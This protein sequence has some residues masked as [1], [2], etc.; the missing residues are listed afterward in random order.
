M[1]YSVKCWKWMMKDEC[2]TGFVMFCSVCNFVVLSLPDTTMFFLPSF[3]SCPFFSCL[4]NWV[5]IWLCLWSL[6]V[7]MKLS[8]MVA[9]T[10]EYWT[11]FSRSKEPNQRMQIIVTFKIVELNYIP[12]K[13]GGFQAK[14]GDMLYD[15][16]TICDEWRHT[17]WIDNEQLMKSRSRSWRWSVEV[18]Q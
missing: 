2:Y 16:I 18:E 12:W 13:P 7:S 14:K 17:S 9:I 4:R 15:I 10:T 5:S 11:K 8:T 3:G 1:S 6:N